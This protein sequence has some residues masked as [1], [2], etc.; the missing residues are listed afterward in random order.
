MEKARPRRIYKWLIIGVLGWILF[1]YP[2]WNT[3]VIHND[4][5]IVLSAR[6]QGFLNLLEQGIRTELGQGRP[7]RIM[8]AFNQS[9]GFMFSNMVLNR[10]FQSLIIMLSLLMGGGMI[11]KLYNNVCLGILVPII[12]LA[13]LPYTFESAVPQAYVGLTVIPII[14]LF[15][16]IIYYI[17]YL[18]KGQ[19]KKWITSIAFYVL[20]ML[21]YE[22]MITFVIVFPILFIFKGEGLANWKKFTIQIGLY[23]CL[24]GGYLLGMFGTKILLPGDYQGTSIKI[25]SLQ[26]SMEIIVNLIKSAVPGYFIQSGKYSFLYKYYT[27][28][29]L[30]EYLL[31]LLTLQNLLSLR[32]ILIVF[33]FLI[34]AYFFKKDNIDGTI[35]YRVWP[36][37]MIGMAYIIIPLLPN[38]ISEMYQGNVGE[39]AFVSLPVSFITSFIIALLLCVVA[40]SIYQYLN[41]TIILYFFS[42]AV[43]FLSLSVQVMN[44]CFMVE[45]ADNF[46]RYSNIEKLMGSS[47]LDK[48]EN[49]K[50]AAS[51]LY[52]TRN[53]LA[54]RDGYWS[55]YIQSHFG[56]QIDFENVETAEIELY[57][58]EDN[59]FCLIDAETIVILSPQPIMGEH[60]VKV[61]KDKYELYNFKESLVDNGLFCYTFYK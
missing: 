40:F 31:Q 25:V 58:V 43:L 39:N 29:S 18:E 7:M 49:K 45:S 13:F 33:W 26:S 47:I 30:K 11:Y 28:N 41:K 2:L 35:N 42:A 34:V 36:T 6:E 46:E 5:V 1:F 21:G 51:D 16:S 54:I 52:E 22:Y 56:K 55:E 23:A 38:S 57:Y 17:E 8:A 10:I 27:G 19:K 24:G 61:S 37:V 14:E 53:T 20:S 50:V 3:G 15:V 12:F 4:E 48:Y 9:L 44:E 32:N 60:G 59:Y